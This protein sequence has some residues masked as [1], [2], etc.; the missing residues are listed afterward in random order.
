MKKVKSRLVEGAL[1]GAALGVAVGMLF[2]PKSGKK[3][4]KDIADRAEDFYKY[5][6]PKLKQIKNMSEEQYKTFMKTAI[7]GYAKARNLSTQEV[8][9]LGGYAQEFWKNFRKH[10]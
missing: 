7:E 3:L 6:S 1:V 9:E 8:Q 5:I 2:A 4:R 10:F